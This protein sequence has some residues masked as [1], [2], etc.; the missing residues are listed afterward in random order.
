MSHTFANVVTKRR[1]PF[2]KGTGTYSVGVG[3]I[4]LGLWSDFQRVHSVMVTGLTNNLVDMWSDLKIK[5]VRLGHL[6]ITNKTI[7]V[8]ITR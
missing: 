3:Q 6:L 2:V 1:Q 7:I 5:Y 4:L 8:L